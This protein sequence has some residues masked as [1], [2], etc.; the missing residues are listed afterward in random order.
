MGI[1]RVL[2][3]FF[4]WRGGAKIDDN[5]LLKF[6]LDVFIHCRGDTQGF[7]GKKGVLT[8]MGMCS[9]RGKEKSIGNEGLIIM[10]L[11]ERRKG[12]KGTP[13]EM[14]FPDDI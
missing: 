7:C 13:V 9:R 11:E 14:R 6:A 8:C 5:I 1:Y 12:I 10:A 3:Q 4:S 2:K